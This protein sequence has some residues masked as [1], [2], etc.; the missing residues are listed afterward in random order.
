MMDLQ[1]PDVLAYGFDGH[2]GAKAIELEAA[3]RETCPATGFRWLHLR[4]NPP[5]T[6]SQLN[7]CGL[8]PLVVEALVAEETRPRCTVHGSGAVIN[9]RGVNLSP[10]ADAED[11]VSVRFWVEEGRVI[12]VW[13]RLL[14]SSKRS[15][16]SRRRP[17]PAI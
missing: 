15:S 9:L 5:E 12:G 2:G 4:H 10:G 17:A 8:D 6:E 3:E 16:V 14:I 11:M 13:R 1:L 7:R